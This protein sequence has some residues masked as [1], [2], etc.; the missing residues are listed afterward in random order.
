MPQRF[1]ARQLRLA[2]AALAAAT[3]FAAP[4]TAQLAA[5]PDLGS[6]PGMTEQE[7][8][9]H[10]L[11]SL[12]AGLNVAALQCGFSR[13]LQAVDTYNAFLRQH[14]DEL[15]GAM[16]TLSAFFVRTSGARAGAKAFDSYST[17][18]YQGFSTFDAQYSF[19]DRAANLGRLALSVP[20]A[21]ASTFAK[22]NLPLFRESLK[23]DHRNSALA[24]YSMGYVMLPDLS[25]GCRLRQGP[26]GL[27]C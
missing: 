20:K 23:A 25:R 2:A 5:A 26:R 24:G 7:V 11:W 4:A 3:S 21:G 6:L 8:A 12:R 15:A 10:A 18:T 16:K 13:S 19:C 22:D 27:R 9:A 17:R 14:S 1:G